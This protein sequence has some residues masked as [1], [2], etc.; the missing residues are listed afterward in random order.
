LG[1]GSTCISH[2]ES[3]H[4]KK[5]FTETSVWL[6]VCNMYMSVYTHDAKYIWTR[7]IGPYLMA[8]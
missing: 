1:C 8:L 3:G 6:L 5:Q 2:D 4:L 7:V